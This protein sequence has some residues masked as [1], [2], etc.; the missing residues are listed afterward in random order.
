MATIRQSEAN[1]L[2]AQ[3]STGPR[4]PEGKAAVRMNALSLER[5]NKDASRELALL[6]LASGADDR[7]ASSPN[8]NLPHL[9]LPASPPPEPAPEP[10]P[11]SGPPPQPIATELSY[12]DIGFV[13]SSR[14]NHPPARSIDPCIEGHGS[15][16]LTSDPVSP[17]PIPETTQSERSPGA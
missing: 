7:S 14:G 4:S 17:H 6:Q 16:L 15:R 2:N 5:S 11:D 10:Q 9:A 13:P 8:A 1:R 3:K 12:R